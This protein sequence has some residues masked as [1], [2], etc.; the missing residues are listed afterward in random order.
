MPN[1][2]H[3]ALETPV[4][5]LAEGMHWLQGTFATRFNR[6]RSERGH[7]FQGRYH[8][9]LLENTGVLTRVVHYI[10]LNPVRNR[11]VPPADVAGFCASSLIRLV[12][13]PRPSWLVADALLAALSLADGAAGWSSYV[14]YLIALADDEREQREQAFGSLS[15]GWAIGSLG[16]RRALAREHG[17]ETGAGL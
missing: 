4:A 16:W 3:I 7:L 1:H 5:N 11:L 9:P 12:A 14:A 10:H 8:A 15:R 13:G 6:F 17:H 2:Y